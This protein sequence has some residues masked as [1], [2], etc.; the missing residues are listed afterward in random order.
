MTDIWMVIFLK[1]RVHV[2]QHVPLQC[3]SSSVFFPSNANLAQAVAQIYTALK[4]HTVCFH[5]DHRLPQW[6]KN[7]M[8]TTLIIKWRKGRRRGQR[9]KNMKMCDIDE[10]QRIF[11]STYIFLGRFLHFSAVVLLSY[12][13][14]FIIYLFYYIVFDVCLHRTC[15]REKKIVDFTCVFENAF[16]RR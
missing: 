14:T 15:N 3:I 4:M 10:P 8:K 6:H 7:S 16:G 12:C 1:L 11:Y 5:C 9:R 13:F 2:N